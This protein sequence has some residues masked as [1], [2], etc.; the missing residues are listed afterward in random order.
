[1]SFVQMILFLLVVVVVLF[2]VHYLVYVTA[3]RIF[4]ITDIAHQRI[5]L[6]VIAFLA[7]SFILASLLARW[8][9][10]SLTRAF[11]F[12]SG[13]WLGLLAN[14]LMALLAALLIAKLGQAA[15]FHINTTYL[16]AV[17]CVLALGVS[18]YGVW[19]AYHPVVKT[20]TVNIPN[21]PAQWENKRIVQISDAHLGF[22]HR[23]SFISN[24]IEKVN[25]AQPD[26]VVI[27]GDLFDGININLDSLVSPLKNIEAPKGIFFVTGNHETYLG[28]EDA[29][30]ALK[31]TGVVNILDDAVADVDGLKVVGIGYPKQGERKDIAAVLDSLQKEFQGYPTILLHHTPG[32]I[33]DVKNSGVNLQLSGHTHRGQLF[34][35][36]YIARLVYKKYEYGLHTQGAYT[37]YTTSGA[38]TWGPP[39]RTG[40]VPEITVITLVATDNQQ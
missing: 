33:E 1:M 18:L 15:G 3:I 16:G 30:A 17:L 21:L 11:Y 40:N 25:S 32:Y 13:F 35:F 8:Y 9:E 29:F 39:M 28:V 14:L 22:V 34:P 4:S 12:A 23:E 37:L 36:E 26:M 2:G 7:V 6:A 5:L 31:K 38:G 24:I 20:I 19:N 27:T 10:D